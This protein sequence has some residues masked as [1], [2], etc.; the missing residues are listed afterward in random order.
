[1]VYPFDR[2]TSETVRDEGLR[3]GEPPWRGSGTVAR[4]ERI[5][6]VSLGCP[7]PTSLFLLAPW[8]LY[9]PRTVLGVDIRCLSPFGVTEGLRGRGL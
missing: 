7:A 1:M 8:F 9:M 4:G 2:G 3:V 5:K 6:T